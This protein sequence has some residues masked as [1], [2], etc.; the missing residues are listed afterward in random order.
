MKSLDEALDAYDYSFPPELIAQRPA[1][2]RDSARLLVLDRASGAMQE[3]IFSQLAQHLPPRSV[4]VMNE[5][6]VVP[7]R[8]TLRKPTGGLVRVLYLAVEGETIK[9]LADRQ[10]APG[11]VLTVDGVTDGPV[12]IVVRQ[13]EKHYYLRPTFPVQELFAVLEKY[14]AAPLPPYIKHTP[15]NATEVKDEYQAVFAKHDGSVAAP[16]ASLHFTE[17]ML[18]KLRDAGHDLEFVTLHVNLGTFAP[19]TSSQLEQGKLHVENYVIDE[20]TAR[21]LNAAKAAHRPIVAV[22][23]TVVRTL[24]TAAAGGQTLTNLAGD[25]DIFIREGYQF[26]FVDALITNFHVPKSSLLML[27]AAFAGRG[28]ILAAYRRAV[29]LKF[30]LFSFGDAMLIK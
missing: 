4:I 23:T 6:K 15:L 27:V 21:R 3:A 28:R 17:G 9:V 5:T 29:D 20:A 1:S 11:D 7:A 30:R 12:F 24:E 8:L 18:A 19:L 13:D 22:G 16:T 14:G 2:P 10:L 25:T 26:A